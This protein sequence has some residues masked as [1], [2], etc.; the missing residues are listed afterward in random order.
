MSPTVGSTASRFHRFD[1]GEWDPPGGWRS[2]SLSADTGELVDYRAQDRVDDILGPQ[3][4]LG[5]DALEQLRHVVV[6]RDGRPHG[7]DAVMNPG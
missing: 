7:H 3:A 5:D 2:F 4:A 6:E 1:V